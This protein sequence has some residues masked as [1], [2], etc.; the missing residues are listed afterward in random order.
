MTQSD[1]TPWMAR[2]NDATLSAPRDCQSRATTF[3]R[4]IR[5]RNLLEG[6]AGT[7]VILGFGI[8]AGMFIAVG[9]LLLALAPILTVIAAIFVIVKLFRDGSMEARRPEEAC[10]S[11]LRRQ[12]TRQRDLLRGVP[13]WYLAPFLPGLFGFYLAFAAKDAATAGWP[14]AIQNI[15][16]HLVSTLALFVFLAW[17]NLRAA[18]KLDREISA[19]DIA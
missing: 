16:F 18:R 13:K 17:L 6:I 1:T 10:A 11:H 19:M 12:L 9:E 4:Q 5:R 15:G 3:E 7:F 14:S 8:T 2:Q